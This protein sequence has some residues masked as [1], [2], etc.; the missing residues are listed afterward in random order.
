MLSKKK[1]RGNLE[2]VSWIRKTKCVKLWHTESELYLI[3]FYKILISVTQA[4]M[5]EKPNALSNQNAQIIQCRLC[6]L[7]G[8]YC[9]NRVA[10]VAVAAAAVKM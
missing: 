3:N 8:K 6:G 7:Y 10:A 2:K 9:S 5:H 1:F 4:I